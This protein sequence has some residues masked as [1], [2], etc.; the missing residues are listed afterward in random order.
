M[1]K[2]LIIFGTRPEAI[3]M[4]PVINSLKEKNCEVNVC[5]TAQHREMLDQVLEFFDIRP[6]FDL[7]IMTKDQDLFTL[8]SRILLEL[9]KILEE[10]KP[11]LVLVQGDTTTTFCATL[12]AFYSGI[13]V[14]HIEAGLRTGNKYAPWPEEVN[15]KLVTHAADVHFAPTKE[16]QKNLLKE[17][18]KEQN[19]YIT[20]NTAIDAL[21][22]AIKII[23]KK[24][25]K[26]SKD[27][28]ILHPQKK[29]ILVTGHRREN[30]GEKLKGVCR[31]L[32]K[33]ATKHQDLQIV[34]PVHL[35]PNV[36][37]TVSEILLSEPNIH[38]LPPLTYP[39]F[40]YLMSK[41]YLIIT[42][43]GGI[44]EEAPTLNK[45]VLV[46][47]ESTE[48]QEAVNCG[49]TLLVGAN[50][51]NIVNKVSALLEDKELYERMCKAKN[52]YGSGKAAQKI[53]EIVCSRSW[54]RN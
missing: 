31:A 15:R 39:N 6:E 28:Q 3:K 24:P 18:I 19:I 41:S 11:H 10:V 36:Q 16:A 7:D 49:A 46:T 51:D 13:A 45:P 50:E 52:P 5:V 54:F 2:I 17:G 27:L 34:Y 22:D 12:A 40:V 53:A 33:I 21:L 32:K 8:T 26:F 42:D 38:L 23:E 20:G 29:I 48:R 44:Q 35:N 9:K 14:G 25:E 30:L 47:R 43:S 4:V 37:K 1:N